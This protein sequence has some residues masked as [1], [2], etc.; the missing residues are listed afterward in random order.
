MNFENIFFR[1]SIKFTHIVGNKKN[2]EKFYEILLLPS[3][4]AQGR[5]KQFFKFFPKN[6]VPKR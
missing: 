2:S 4:F 1:F 5:L 3:F 6:Y